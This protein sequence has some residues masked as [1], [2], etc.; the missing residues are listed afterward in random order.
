MWCHVRRS[1]CLPTGAPDVLDMFL[2]Y[3]WIVGARSPMRKINMWV[4]SIHINLPQFCTFLIE[5]PGLC[6][7]MQ[8]FREL[9]QNFSYQKKKNVFI[10]PLQISHFLHCQ[11]VYRESFKW[12][13]TKVCYT[14]ECEPDL[15]F[16][17]QN[18]GVS[19]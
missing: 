11:P 10:H 12:N 14:F 2:Q 18:L 19:S 5:I 13:L 4:L 17:V 8:L 6:A 7:L 9:H 3:A 15:K 1:G 16:H